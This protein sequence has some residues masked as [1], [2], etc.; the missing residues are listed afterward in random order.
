MR[1]GS[2]SMA[3][4][5]YRRPGVG[6]TGM[7]RSKRDWALS[8]HEKGSSIQH[9]LLSGFWRWTPSPANLINLAAEPQAV[10]ISPDD[11]Y[12][13]FP[14]EHSMISSCFRFHDLVLWRHM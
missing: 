8:M 3:G 9:A 5:G 10:H 7:G 11:S 14:H 12:W 1:H 4:E 2:G 13:A 6:Y